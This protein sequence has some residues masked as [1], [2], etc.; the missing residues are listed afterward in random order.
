MS[1][2]AVFFD[3][4]GVINELIPPKFDRG[5]RLV[6]ELS[7]KPGIS[8][9]ISRLV[10]LDFTCIVITNQPD[11]SRGKLSDQTLQDIHEQILVSIPGIARIYTCPHDNHDEC[12]CRKPKPGLVERA[13]L[14]FKIDASKSFFVGDRWTD[15]LA[16]HLSGVSSVLVSNPLAN[17]GGSQGSKPG[18]LEPNFTID[19]V[20]DLLPI[21]S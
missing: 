19:N 11:V 13:L 16:A 10:Q 18:W 14:D 21:V 2:R 5:P 20:L 9:L 4:D 17:E 7:I 12:A 1:E 15:I 6:Q 8:E 3:R